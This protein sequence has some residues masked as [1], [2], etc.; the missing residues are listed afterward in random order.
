MGSTGPSTLFIVDGTPLHFSM[1]PG[2]DRARVRTLIEAHGGIFHKSTEPT[3]DVI[4]L[5]DPETVKGSAI[6]EAYD[7]HYVDACIAGRRLLDRLVFK[8]PDAPPSKKPTQPPREYK[9]YT[10]EEDEAI[11]EFVESKK[12]QHSSD[13]MYIK[14]NALWDAAESLKIT[15]HSATSMR[16]RYLNHLAPI[17]EGLAR[18]M[19]ELPATSGAP[20]AV[21]AAAT[22][23]GDGKGERESG[24][25]ADGST[26]NAAAAAAVTRTEE[27]AG[28]PADERDGNDAHGD[29][30]ASSGAVGRV[31]AGTLTSVTMTTTTITLETEVRDAGEPGAGGGGAGGGG[32]E[33]S[34][35]ADSGSGL[36]EADVGG[37]AVKTRPQSGRGKRQRTG[38]DGS[39]KGAAKGGAAGSEPEGDREAPDAGASA[40]GSSEEGNAGYATCDS[41]SPP[42]DSQAGMEDD[43]AGQRDRPPAADA[44]SPQ[45]A[46]KRKREPTAAREGENG[47][48]PATNGD[49]RSPR[50]AAPAPAA[51]AAKQGKSEDQRNGGAFMPWREVAPT[52]PK[53]ASSG[54]P[55]VPGSSAF[56]PGPRSPL[57][58]HAAKG[59][60]KGTGETGTSRKE[61]GVMIGS[62]FSPWRG[63]AGKPPPPP[64]HGASR[65]G[66]HRGQVAAGAATGSAKSHSCSGSGS[67]G[68]DGGQRQASSGGGH[69]GA[70]HAEENHGKPGI[71]VPEARQK[72]LREWVSNLKM[73]TGCS[74]AQVLQT[75]MSVS[76]DFDRALLFLLS[77]SKGAPLAS[78]KTWTRE[79]DA[80][81]A[82]HE[83]VDRLE[84]IYGKD[85]V[86][87]R[88]RFL[89]V[90]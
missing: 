59:A 13:K 34:R 69:A 60:N 84:K 23:T 5:M 45:S 29:A 16:D 43:S 41:R 72:Q 33:G 78:I 73:V 2:P 51:V 79:D 83:S 40:P 70:P 7:F 37:P 26:E 42:E 88:K 38:Q 39:S 81:L 89:G 64:S 4:M 28:A 71:N 58:A 18:A 35:N 54:P 22:A 30:P 53:S 44:K 82:R 74:D 85:G 8:I 57:G 56:A 31:I 76:G 32:A 49:S 80:A 17:H 6:S 11:I 50:H 36:D 90:D 24:P 19:A 65:D 46:G 14:G 20:G 87:A 75:L 67:S 27:A 61:N 62:G 3:G 55:A 48:N 47:A 12:P 66:A 52:T 10:K 9:R 86:M 1:P 77:G 68:G 15:S 21:A 25:S 63:G